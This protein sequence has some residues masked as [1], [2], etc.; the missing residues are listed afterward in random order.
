[1]KRTKVILLGVVFLS[2]LALSS[3]GA[4]KAK[5]GKEVEKKECCE[6]KD[7]TACCAKKDST[8]CASAD[9]TKKVE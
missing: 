9:S 2:A 6:K 3:C 7:S 1:M 4:K 5:E 8:A